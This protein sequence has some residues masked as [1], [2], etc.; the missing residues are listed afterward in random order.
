M[1]GVVVSRVNLSPKFMKELL[2]AMAD[3]YS[4]WQAAENIKN[5][6]EAPPATSE[7]GPVRRGERSAGRRRESLRRPAGARPSPPVGR[8][9]MSNE[10]AS[11]LR[12]LPP[13]QA[14]CCCR[15][16]PSARMAGPVIPP[17]PRL[18]GGT[19][20]R[21]EANGGDP[22]SFPGGRSGLL[23]RQRAQDRPERRHLQG[24][25]PQHGVGREVHRGQGSAAPVHVGGGPAEGRPVGAGEPHHP[26]DGAVRRHQ[27]Q[28]GLAP[29]GRLQEPPD[30]HPQRQLRGRVVRAGDE[31]RRLRR[32][33]HPGRVARARRRHHQGRRRL[34]RPGGRQVLGPR[35]VGDRR[36]HAQGLR[37]RTPRRSPSGRAASASSSGPASP[38]ISTTRP[39][40]VG[41]APSGAARSSRPS[42]CAAPVRSRSAM[43]RRSS[44]T[45]TAS[46]P[47]TCSPRTTCGP[48]RRARRCSPRS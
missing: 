36:G 1:N 35:D 38:P 48:T 41:T 45:C 8:A 26:H 37:R 28:H 3:N 42:R 19:S 17:F 44:P 15:R 40:G 9:G 21:T 11:R 25:A 13:V 2:D 4:K 32:D 27:R 5:L 30:R 23:Q 47:T 20:P 10:P 39:G 31:V 34:V 22:S 18:R 14:I 16:G 46:T 29:R 6:P 7:R 33:H 24:G 12:F 43:P